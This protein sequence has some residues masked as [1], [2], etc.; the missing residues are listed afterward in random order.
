[1]NTSAKGNLFEKRVFEL[2]QEL[3]ANDKLYLSSK[4]SQVFLKKPYYSRDRQKDIVFDISIETFVENA[5]CPSLLTIIECKNYN[6]SVPVDDIEEFDSK[7]RQVGEHNIKGIFATNSNFQESAYSFAKSK[8]IGLI[9]IDENKD[10]NWFNYRKDKS[11]KR[12]SFENIK[13]N[14]C[15]ENLEN[16]SFFSFNK[17]KNFD[18]VPELFKELGIIDYYE[19]NSK[20]IT[21]KYLSVNQIQDQIEKLPLINIYNNGVLNTENLCSILTKQKG[22]NFHFDKELDKSKSILGKIIFK[23]L[24]IH[25]SS[26]LYSDPNR[27]RFTLAHEIGHLLLHYEQLIEFIDEY[28]D[29]E[30]SISLNHTLSLN[31]NKRLEI[32][33][34]LFASSLLMPKELVYSIVNKYFQ[35]ERIHKGYLF[36]DNQPCNIDL[37]FRLLRKFQETFGVSKEAAKYRLISLDLLKDNSNISIDNLLRR[38]L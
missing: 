13:L 4:R 5:E 23:P 16:H 17:N 1:M 2:F 28:E 21:I 38:V 26:N 10:Y 24:E 12:L 25:I 29:S 36:L 37:A 15:S 11:K 20:F 32:Q 34:N 9:R 22:V 7:L 18:T 6:K 27:W 14:L 3:L 31:Y 8:N 30:N 33:A 35:D 19:N